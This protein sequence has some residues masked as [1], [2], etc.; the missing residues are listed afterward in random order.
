MPNYFGD[1]SFTIVIFREYL[2]EKN[3]SETTKQIP[4]KYFPIYA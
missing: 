2:K 4:F 3:K 1:I